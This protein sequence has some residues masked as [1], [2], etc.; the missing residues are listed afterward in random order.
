MTD[1]IFVS[2]RDALDAACRVFEPLPWI[3][4]DT[5]FQ[6]EQTYFS[7]LALVQIA[8]P[9]SI[10]CIDPLA[11]DQ[12][13]SLGE[14]LTRKT[15]TKVFH[16]A[17]QDLEAVFHKLGIV[18]SPVFD[19][20]VAAA[21]LGLGEQLGYAALIRQLIRVEL[22]KTQSRTDWMKRPLSDAQLRY[23]A[24]DVRYLREVYPLM[25]DSLHR[26]GR[27]GWVENELLAV[28][29]P[30]LY[31]PSP[32]TVWTMVRGAGK[33]GRKQ[34]N[35]LRHLAKWREHEAIKRNRP[36]RW[37]LT[38]DVLLDLALQH[39]KDETELKAVRLLSGKTAKR[40]IATLLGL[41]AKALDEPQEEW[42]KSLNRER[43]SPREEATLDML[44]AVVRLQADMNRLSAGQIA[45]RGELLRLIRGERDLS[46]LGGW[47]KE[48]AGEI[49]LDV[50]Q[51]KQLLKCQNGK[52]VLEKAPA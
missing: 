26:L 21:L 31:A 11:I 48:I 49:V 44:M 40:H 34:L 16:A 37:I 35:I 32:E 13:D 5:E 17:G 45:A 3:A 20:Q 30:A 19:T 1:I 51:G 33:L 2:T 39:P 29:D 43:P 52:V 36:R 8:T 27:A 6:R 22:S 50:L 28:S 7:M 41:I 25:Q 24:D 10:Y 15:I 9:D 23:A 4:V 47:R 42:P 12:L 46:L 14:I 18:P 38:D